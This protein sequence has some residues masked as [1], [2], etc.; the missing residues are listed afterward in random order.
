MELILILI[1]GFFVIKMGLFGG[2]TSVW[3]KSDAATGVTNLLEDQKRKGYFW[4]DTAK[5]AND[6]INWAWDAEP[7]IFNGKRGVR[8]HKVST[9]IY[10]LAVA[11]ER[12]KRQ[13][14]QNTEGVVNAFCVGMA[15]LHSHRFDF[16]HVDKML[17][18]EA[19]RIAAPLLGDDMGTFDEMTLSPSPS[20]TTIAMAKELMEEHHRLLEE[21]RARIE[22]QGIPYV[23]D[24]PSEGVFQM[25]NFPY[26]TY[27]EWQAVYKKAAVEANP[28]LQIAGTPMS[29]LDLL[30]DAPSKSAYEHHLHP[31]ILGRKIGENFNPMEVGFED[32]S[33]SSR[34]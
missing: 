26:Q 17:L 8:P 21:K 9:A 32:D 2:L 31:E 14:H 22:A 24:N 13:N 7:S 1:I 10:A 16:S 6:Y 18:Q 28:E 33:G 3:K 25:V 23:P 11:A 30:S 12:L 20:Q 27:E 5:A 4:G 15:T 34:K 29:L 19:M